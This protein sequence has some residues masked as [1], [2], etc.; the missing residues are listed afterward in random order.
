MGRGWR[1]TGWAGVVVAG[2][3]A[4]SAVPGSG[5]PARAAAPPVV[6]SF[7]AGVAAEAT[8]PGSSPPGANVWTCRPSP[9]HPRPVVLIHGTI[10]DR[11]LSWQALSPLLAGAG[12]C[13]F[14]LDYGG[15]TPTDPIGGVTP[16]EGSAVQL[17]RFV[18]RVRAAT[19][20]AK[21]DLVGHS[22]GGGALPRYYLRF[23]GGAA[24][25]H[26]LVGLSPS[27][28]GT[29][30]SGF[31]TL[32]GLVPGGPGLVFGPWCAACLEQFRGS[33]FLARLNAGGDTLPGVAYT[34]IAT[35][36]DEVVTPY[37]TQF[38]AG[39]G[40]TNI[41]VQDQCPLDATDH[42]GIIYDHI[43][44]NDAVRALDPASKRTVACTPV[45]PV[46][47]G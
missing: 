23:L 7:A 33:S 44:L 21:V 42:V 34:V 47:G 31:V 1:R 16:I 32:L 8:S 20:A 24:K 4:A 36:H 9:A 40:V 45:L 46:E 27:N 19:G 29:D 17:S 37:R 30:V 15:A 38:L 22:Q 41:T 14:A 25:V 3:L 11:T 6:Y 18:D 12:W 26:A 35:S 5:F 39:P 2:L 28:H 43:A 10:F 13:V